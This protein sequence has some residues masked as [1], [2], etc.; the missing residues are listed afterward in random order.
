MA[1]PLGNSPFKGTSGIRRILNAFGY[2]LAGLSY[3]WQGEAAFRQVLV[4]AG[5]GIAVVVAL[6]PPLWALAVIVL[7]HFLC[8]II[9]L[10]NS[11]IE[12]AVDHT[13]LEHHEFAKRAK[14]LGS[15]A[16]MVSLITLMV[17]WIIAILARV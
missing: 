2:S 10:I 6:Q 12:A 15:A 16:Q 1:K 3:A 13:S 9:E 14:D 8:V 5:A 17:A 4:L 11:A 7:C